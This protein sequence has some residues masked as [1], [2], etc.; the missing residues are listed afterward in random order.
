M[1]VLNLQRCVCLHLLSSGIK[2]VGH[3]TC[4]FFVFNYVHVH[5]LVGGERLESSGDTC[6]S[7]GESSPRRAMRPHFNKNRA[8]YKEKMQSS[9]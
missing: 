4:V 2:G 8:F 6:C 3:H 5:V 7:Q 1:L 9:S